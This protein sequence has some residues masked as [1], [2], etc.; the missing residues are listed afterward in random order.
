MDLCSVFSLSIYFKLLYIQYRYAW[1]SKTK[2]YMND[3]S[4][5]E[6]HQP[7]GAEALEG[8]DFSPNWDQPQKKAYTRTFSDRP[9]RSNQRDH[10]RGERGAGRDR[11]SDNRSREMGSKHADRKPQAA[12][13]RRASVPD[14]PLEITILPN[15]KHLAS[16]VRQVHQTH[17]AY[18]LME[19]ANLLIKDADAC[20]VKLE[21]SKT[22]TEFCLFQCSLSGFF[23]V[24]EAAVQSHR[25]R[26]HLDEL[27]D[28][29]IEEQDLPTGHFPGVSRCTKTGTLLGP[30]NH[31]SY[32][33][34]VEQWHASHFSDRPLTECKSWLEV[35]KDEEVIEAWKVAFSKQE[36]FKLKI[37]PEGAL[38]TRPQAEQ[39]ML[40]HADHAVVKS[41]KV[42]APLELVLAGGDD[43]LK[44]MV[45]RA[46]VKERR[47]PLNLSHAMRAAFRHMKLF[48]FKVGKI[49]YVTA[50]KPNK[51]NES[52]VAEDVLQVLGVLKN[53]PGCTRD[54]LLQAVCPGVEA[55]SEEGRT[56]LKPL[57]WLI[58]RGHIVEYFNGKL[59]LP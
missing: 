50:I 1:I 24:D 48:L 37:E 10:G 56:A 9:K 18:P 42:V 6:K 36:R 11:R 46:L 43:V 29:V 33:L 23:A 44:A 51:L 28:V 31:H 32:A 12:D 27:F 22:E 17:R 19:L 3:E 58:E 20:R 57:S 38:L 39:Y 34:A 53:K 26:H 55:D 47:F 4:S 41:R 16:V 15:Q 2:V 52:G 13:R 59:A 21:V 54:E 40:R 8:L 30:S 5:S 7:L 35:V 14:Y 45:N 49:N 25:V